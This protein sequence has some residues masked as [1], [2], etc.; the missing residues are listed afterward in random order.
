MNPSHTEPVS[1]TPADYSDTLYRV[2]FEVGEWQHAARDAIRTFLQQRN[3]PDASFNVRPDA[4]RERP[5][6]YEADLPMQLIPE[7]VQALA[8]RNIAVYQVVRMARD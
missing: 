3:H 4:V 6:G 5:H 8:A 7:V 1:G 2:Y